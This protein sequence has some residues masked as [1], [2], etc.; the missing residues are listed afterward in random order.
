MNPR[1]RQCLSPGGDHRVEQRLGVLLDTTPGQILRPQGDL[2]DGGDG[3]DAPGPGVPQI[4]DDGF[5][6]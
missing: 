4:N 5:G 1:L 2:G 3:G 6:G